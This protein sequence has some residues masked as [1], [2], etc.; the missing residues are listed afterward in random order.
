MGCRDGSLSAWKSR[1]L[2]GVFF[3]M[4]PWYFLLFCKEW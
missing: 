3:Q 4:H 1:W 2:I